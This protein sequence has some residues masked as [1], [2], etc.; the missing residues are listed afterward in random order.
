MATTQLRPSQLKDAM[1]SQE[2]L[3]ISAVPD[4][5]P[6]DGRPYLGSQWLLGSMPGWEKAYRTAPAFAVVDLTT[7]SFI[8]LFDWLATI[9]L[10]DKLAATSGVKQIDLLVHREDRVPPRKR[11]VTPRKSTKLISEVYSVD[12]VKAAERTRNLTG[13]MESLDTYATLNP[14]GRQTRVIYPGVDLAIAQKYA[15]YGGNRLEEQTILMGLQRIDK[16]QSCEDFLDS[17]RILNWRDK[18]DEQ[19]RGSPLFRSDEVWRVFAHELAANIF[20]HAGGAGFISARVVRLTG[21]KLPHWVKRTYSGS[22]AAIFEGQET[23][24]L[25]LCAVDAGRGFAATLGESFRRRNELADENPATADIVAFAFDEFGTS[26]EGESNWIT[27]RHALNRLLMVVAKYG[28]ALKVRTGDVEVS[29][30]FKDS[31]LP[32]KLGPHRGYEPS[33]V[34]ILDAQVTGSQLQVLLPLEP[35]AGYLTKDN[36]KRRSV[37][38]LGLPRGYVTEPQHVRGHLVPIGERLD[39]LGPCLTPE[40][41]RL[42]I[43][44]SVSL[45]EELALKRPKSEPLV[46]DFSELKW[47]V[48]QFE[49][50][51]YILQNVLLYRPA[52]LIE[53]DA[54]LVREVRALEIAA[55]ETT[56]SQFFSVSPRSLDLSED[57][58]FETFSLVH[59]IFLCLDDEDGEHF[60]GLPSSLYEEALLSLVK[61]ALTIEEMVARY[62]GVEIAVLRAIL[63]RINPLF[64]NSGGRW[65]S[66]WTR[67]NIASE[68]RRVLN[69]HFDDVAKRSK[70]WRGA[71]GGDGRNARFFLPWQDEWRE[72]FLETSRILSRGRQLDEAA[73]RLNARLKRLLSETPNGLEEVRVLAAVSAPALLLATAM[74]RWWP[75]PRRPAVADLSFYVM[76]SHPVRLPVVTRLGGVVLVQDVLDKGVMSG[77]LVRALARQQTRL[78]AAIGFVRFVKNPEERD[79]TNQVPRLEI[80][81]GDRSDDITSDDS[82]SQVLNDA[83]VAVPRPLP[84]QPPSPDSDDS[85]S[86]WVEPRALRPVRYPTLRREFQT[87]RDPELERSDRLLRRFDQEEE[88]CLIAAGHF[89]YGH[90][91]YEV[92]LDVRRA[93][94]GGI[95][96]EIAR[97]VADVCE[98][99]IP[100][101]AEWET[102]IGKKLQGDVT[103]V[104][105]PV[106][107]QVHYL[108]PKVEN[109]L[110]QRG[111]RQLSWMLEATLYSGSGPSYYFPLQFRRLLVRAVTLAA[112]A[113]GED[114]EPVRLLIIDDTLATGRTATTILATLIRE[115]DKIRQQL[116]VSPAVV[117]KAL[118][119]I[120]YFTVLNQTSQETQILWRSITGIGRGL[121]PL[122]IEEYAPLMGVRVY[123]DLDCA[124]CRDL[125]LLTEEEQV[126]EHSSS[127]DA[128]LWIQERR[129]QLEPIAVDSPDFP[130]VVPNRLPRSV[131]VVRSREAGRRRPR[132]L[133]VHADTAIWRFLELMYLAYPPV[134]ALKALGDAW[135][136]QADNKESVREYE[137]YRWAVLEWC[138]RNWSRIDVGSTQRQFVQCC[139]QEV[140]AGT[141]LVELLLEA[142]GRLFRDPVA[143]KIFAAAVERLREVESVRL[144]GLVSG[145]AGDDDRHYELSSRLVRGLEL[146]LLASRN[147]LWREHGGRKSEDESYQGLLGL[148]DAAALQLENGQANHLQSIKDRF[149]RPQR[150]PDPRWA[151]E[152]IAEALF[153][154]RRNPSPS[155]E[156]QVLPTVLLSCFAAQP[157]KDDLH[158]L[159][160]SLSAFVAALGDL[161]VYADFSFLDESR[162][163]VEQAQLVAQHVQNSLG[164]GDDWGPDQENEASLLYDEVVEGEFRQIFARHF[165]DSLEDIKSKLERRAGEGDSNKRLA[166]EVVVNHDLAGVHVLASAQRLLVSLANRAIDPVAFFEGDC[167]SKVMVSQRARLGGGEE[168]VF[169]ILTDFADARVADLAT[170]TTASSATEVFQL[171]KFGGSASGWVE[172]NETEKNDGFKAVSE[173][174]VPKGWE[175]R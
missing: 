55:G 62:P 26:K 169:R 155:P 60:L 39:L 124:I 78:L 89:A 23:G 165:H 157:S 114:T 11:N 53:I 38:E 149:A 153:R 30:L 122:V 47:T 163:I 95:G 37:F 44:R 85:D 148:L 35:H 141:P 1:N 73:Q 63:H 131:N 72:T 82:L 140:V 19:F 8:T 133:P 129:R 80:M 150:V 151:I 125:T 52:L 117:R 48:P 2:S 32:R 156:H 40:Q 97:W 29:Y 14:V 105:M 43:D 42:F 175:R 6:I 119:W 13:F 107:S 36:N 54:G 83:L 134:E 138:F 139:I 99:R 126:A 101:A 64:T 49:T 94:S 34:R 75:N 158:L 161:A 168:V 147:A 92:A 27:K 154:N 170:R 84:A 71:A 45:A 58:F 146:F 102:A 116:R 76:L 164:R 145:A 4:Q 152:I 61:E 162:H 137:R 143:K 70:A 142:G 67:Q 56:L 12:E 120:R 24:V 59:S 159:H 110:A 7:V 121:L 144:Q 113:P 50:F 167:R 104:L 5:D 20:E 18:M 15:F 81:A 16:L 10:V 69:R 31:L 136:P 172:P 127:F 90:R 96:D 21:G 79:R 3:I 33:E 9:A 57:R 123:S 128:A 98:G 93:L 25:E 132:Y 100:R 87:G 106:H 46:L 108:W 174:A 77:R 41:K 115:L 173:I 103:A 28:G 65:K 86:W 66:S 166:F 130:G 112:R 171:E 118:G 88:G 111:R 74:H 68:K 135:P 91:H 160:G 22:T 109:L 17:A 51:M